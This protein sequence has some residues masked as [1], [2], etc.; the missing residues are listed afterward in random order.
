MEQHRTCKSIS[1][2][3]NPRVVSSVQQICE[4]KKDKYFPQKM[5]YVSECLRRLCKRSF[6]TAN[7]WFGNDQS[8]QTL[9]HNNPPKMTKEGQKQIN[10]KSQVMN[11]VTFVNSP[12][13]RSIKPLHLCCLN[14][15]KCFH[16]QHQSSKACTTEAKPQGHSEGNFNLRQFQL[17]MV[18]CY[19]AVTLLLNSNS[20]DCPHLTLSQLNVFTKNWNSET[21]N[22]SYGTGYEYLSVVYFW[23]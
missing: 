20:L 16:Q 7:K 9:K 3:V 15:Y 13:H 18:E 6:K 21:W 8:F 2:M 5:E 12:D 11:C 10:N 19:I 1:R 17:T 14:V 23:T 22:R 4:I